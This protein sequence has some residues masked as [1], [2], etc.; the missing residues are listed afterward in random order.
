[1]TE[2][3]AARKSR[4]ALLY[5]AAALLLLL[6]AAAIYLFLP[7]L[8][9]H[10]LLSQ[11]AALQVGKS[12]FA[13]A[14][15]VA[16]SMDAAPASSCSATECNWYRRIDNTS[17]PQS[18]IGQGTSLS[19]GFRVQNG[20]V[21]ERALAYKIGSDVI[22]AP[23]VDIEER[24]HWYGKGPDPISIQTQW[25]AHIPRFSIFVLMVPAVPSE[26]RTRYTSFNLSCLWKYNGCTD[27]KEL[28]PTVDW[29]D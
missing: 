21:T 7:T 4:T 16:A 18:W 24:S 19:L 5:T 28:L 22:P 1:M 6:L 3:F 2:T 13:E 27:A 15:S 29:K 10:R 20:I 8:R 26:T 25:T 23:Y 17:L 14:Q 11:V 12:T 9:A